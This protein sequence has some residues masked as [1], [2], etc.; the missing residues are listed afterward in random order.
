MDG[1]LRILK[2]T[3]KIPTTITPRQ[4]R[5]QLLVLELLDEV[6]AMAATDKATSIWFEYSLEF[7]RN[8]EILI[9]SAITLGLTADDLDNFFIAASKL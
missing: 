2:V 3:N 7:E 6:E 5:L 8:H 9:A 4:F 1:L